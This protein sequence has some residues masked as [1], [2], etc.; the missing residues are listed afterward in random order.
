M[1]HLPAHQI[2]CSITTH[3]H[4]LLWLCT[5]FSPKTKQPSFHTS[6]LTRFSALWILSFLRAK[7][8]NSQW[9]GHWA[10]CI[11]SHWEYFEGGQH[12]LKG[13]CCYGEI[14][15]S[16]NHLIAPRVTKL[17]HRL[18]FKI[19]A[20][21][22]KWKVSISK[23]LPVSGSCPTSFL[24][25]SASLSSSPDPASCSTSAC[26]LCISNWFSELFCIPFRDFCLIS[27]IFCAFFLVFSSCCL[28]RF[29]LSFL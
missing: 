3:P 18:V 23:C 11:K 12:L 13:R 27:S 10:H 25:H 7:S 6:L 2:Q 21:C 28:F 8:Q 29:S 16:R 17:C 1:S 19:T 26:I 4:T 15:Q 5:H 14:S 9:H 22:Q 24:Y 20:V